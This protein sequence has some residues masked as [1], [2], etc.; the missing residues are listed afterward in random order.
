MKLT[1]LMLAR[2]EEWIIGMSIR[3]ALA[4]C[5]DLV[6]LDHASTDRTGEIINDLATSGPY[7][8][9]IHTLKAH[10]VN[11]WKETSFRQ[12]TLEEA[13]RLGAT[14]MAIVD[15]DEVISGNLVPAM[16]AFVEELLPG[17]LLSLPMVSPWKGTTHYRVDPCVWTR[18][19]IDVAFCDSGTLSWEAADGYHHHHRAPRGILRSQHPMIEGTPKHGGVMHLQWVDW[20][21]IRAKHV[22][23][24]MMETVAYPGR[25]TPE[26][27][28]VMYGQALDEQGLQLAPIPDAWWKPYGSA[29]PT[30]GQASWHVAEC[31][32]LL[33]EHG[34]E[35]FRGLE[36]LDVVG[37]GQRG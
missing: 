30:V 3:G 4:W 23:Y 11:G 24:R 25:R 26:E 18:S 10:D 13:R 22:W 5:D 33:R 20:D 27:L 32:R 34:P 12:Q 6:V 28:N 7:S 31:E 1:G 19:V 17:E 9:R 35:T 8:G 15:A 2:N 29:R 16:R 14:H 37:G 36:L 21:R